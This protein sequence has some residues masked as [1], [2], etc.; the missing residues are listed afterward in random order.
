MMG[1]VFPAFSIGSLRGWTLGAAVAAALVCAGTAGAGVDARQDRQ[2]DRTA[3]GV[4]N[5]SLTRPEAHRL[6]R[7]QRHIAR[8]E[9]RMR[10]DG[11][12][13]GPRERLR[14]D[15]ALDRSSRHIHHAKHDRQERR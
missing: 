13:L 5:G 10:A 2:D 8:M 1:R 7:Q 6:H 4:A 3:A 12:G 15:R 11:G 14:L 9:E